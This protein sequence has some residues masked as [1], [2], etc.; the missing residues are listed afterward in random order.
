VPDDSD[1]TPATVAL[2][3]PADAPFYVATRSGATVRATNVGTTGSEVRVS[4]AEGS[5]TFNRAD[6]VGVLRVPAAP[7]APEAWIT[8]WAAEDGTVSGGEPAAGPGSP[9]PA[10]APALS[11]RLHLLQLANG[12]VVQVDGFWIEA[13]ETASGGS[14]GSRGSR[15]PRSPGS[16]RRRSSPS[17]DASRHGS[18]AGSIP[19]GS[20]SGWSRACSAFA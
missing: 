13:G 4:T 7:G 9:P 8:L 20:R 6:L 10:S 1:E 17:A 16:C 3:P 5:L 18:S 14:G 2:P 15:W 11:D 12:V 19:T